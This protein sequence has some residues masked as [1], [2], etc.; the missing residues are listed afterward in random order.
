MEILSQY[1]NDNLQLIQDNQSTYSISDFNVN[2]DIIKLSV[3]SD[4]GSFLLS[5]DLIINTD[6]FIKNN[7][8]F[9]KP[10]E[11]LDRE[12]FAEG[13]YNLQFDFINRLPRESDQ[14]YFDVALPTSQQGP[15]FEDTMSI[16]LQI[17]QFRMIRN[18]K[19]RIVLI[20]C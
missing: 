10:N 12:G 5:T 3:F 15:G 19:I 1:S 13:N 18:Y 7:Q 11:Y 17:F 9:L 6:F 16:V 20:Q 8:L 2:S 4:A 14:N